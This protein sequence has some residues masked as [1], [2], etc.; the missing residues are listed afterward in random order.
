MLWFFLIA[1]FL[2]RL[3]FFFSSPGYPS[4]TWSTTFLLASAPPPMVA[5]PSQMKPE[6]GRCVFFPDAFI[7]QAPL[8]FFFPLLLPPLFSTSSLFAASWRPLVRWPTYFNFLFPCFPDRD[9]KRLLYLARSAC[10]A[11]VAAFLF[12]SPAT[13]QQCLDSRL[14]RF[15]TLLFQL[16]FLG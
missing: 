9:S 10:G 16:P 1:H 5:R 8:I 15:K 12:V 11:L 14:W 4:S 2:S 7:S 3:N 13:P 6:F